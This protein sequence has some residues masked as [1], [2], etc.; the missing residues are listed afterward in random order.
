MLGIAAE[1]VFLLLSNK[2]LSALADPKEEKQFRAIMER[3]ALKPKLDFVSRKILDTQSKRP[4]DLPDNVNIMISVI[5]DFIR[6]QRNDLGHPKETP[7]N[8]AERMP[9]SI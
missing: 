4:R 5:Y 3:M 6:T 8:V 9:S 2:L 7:P 1:R